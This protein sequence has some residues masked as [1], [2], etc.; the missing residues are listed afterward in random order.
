ML[1][2]EFEALA[3]KKHHTLKVDLF[4]EVNDEYMASE[5]TKQEFISR[6]CGVKNT[7]DDILWKVIKLHQFH[8]RQALRGNPSATPE[9]LADY[10]YMIMRH[11]LAVVKYSR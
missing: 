10:D 3:M 4:A 7:A 1:Q 8:N 2:Q 6:F 11:L 5:E 9:K